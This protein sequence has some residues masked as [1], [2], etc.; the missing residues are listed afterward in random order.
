M[1]KRIKKIEITFVKRAKRRYKPEGRRHCKK[2]GPKHHLR[3]H[4]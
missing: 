3:V 4:A 2:L 1:V